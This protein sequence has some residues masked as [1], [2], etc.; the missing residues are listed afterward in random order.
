MN[1]DTTALE[2]PATTADVARQMESRQ[3]DGSNNAPLL[4]HDV[5]DRL[6]ADWANVQASFVDEPRQSVQKADELVAFAIKQIAETF[7]QERSALESQW[8]RDGEV[9][10]EDL[11]V[12]L[13][14][15]RSFFHR[16]LSM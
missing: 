1:S 8:D 10:T 16:L 12:A 7:S 2:R 9:S 15:Y 11:R 13:T 6:R 14:R 4:S 5:T 3:G